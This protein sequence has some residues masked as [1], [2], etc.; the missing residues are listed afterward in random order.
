MTHNSI[1]DI[2]LEVNAMNNEDHWKE[3]LQTGSVD[4]YLK[5]KGVH[6]NNVSPENK[7]I[8]NAVEHS[9]T[10]HKGPQYK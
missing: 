7:E 8:L 9:G 5:Y 4:S 1:T 6:L 10:D 3:F 2:K